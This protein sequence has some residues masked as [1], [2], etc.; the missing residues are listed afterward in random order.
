MDGAVMGL[1]NEQALVDQAA[2]EPSAFAAIYDYYFPRVYNYARYRVRDAQ[3]AEDITSQVFERVW[4]KIGSYHPEQGAFAHWLFAIA[5][6]AVADHYRSKRRWRW[7]PIDF[8]SGRP[9]HD[10]PPEEITVRDETWARVLSIVAQLG[11]RERE[12][13]ALKY[14]ARLTHR[15]IAELTGLTESNV[16]VILHRTVKRLRVQLEKEGL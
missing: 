11:E 15:E 9:S 10:L 4:R 13:V 16:S 8:L 7:L 6:N 1:A 2:V 12:L 5:R 3:A 14:G